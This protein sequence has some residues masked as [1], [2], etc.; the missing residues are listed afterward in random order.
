MKDDPNNANSTLPS[1][2]SSSLLYSS[3]LMTQAQLQTENNFYRQ[4]MDFLKEEVHWLKEQLG[5]LK[6]DRFGKKTEQLSTVQPELFDEAD[7]DASGELIETPEAE[8]ETLIYTRKK[9]Q[10]SKRY[11]DTSTLPRER[12]LHDLPEAEK[13]CACGKEKHKIGDDIREEIQAQRTTLKVIEHV[14]PKYA[15]RSCESVS[16]APAVEL[17]IPKSKAGTSLLV[18]IIL[19]KYAYHLP[20]YRQAKMFKIHGLNVSDNTLGYWVMSAAKV[21]EP[22]NLA[23][24]KALKMSTALQVDETP[25][26]ILKPDKKAYLWAYHSYLPGKRFIVFDFSLTRAGVNVN[27]RLDNFS[28]LLQ[29]DG[30]SG[31]NQQRARE[32]IINLGCWDHARRYFVDVVKAAGNNKTGKAGGILKLIG[33]LYKIEAEIKNATPEERYQYRQQYAKSVLEHVKSYADKIHAPP[34]SLLGKAVHYLKTQWPELI[35]YIEYGHAELANIWVENQIRPFAVGRRNWLFIGNETSGQ[36]AA[37]LYSLI[38]SCYLNDID[39]HVYLTYVLNQA[40]AMR[41]GEVDPAQL[42]PHTIDLTKLKK[43]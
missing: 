6:N 37:L 1:I 4:K 30:Y 41:K 25:V 21:L 22:L 7:L 32:D 23:L 40:H 11:L 29:S 36:R 2:V 39:P 17:P 28:G 20:L 24:F 12:K 16:M 8:E 3:L 35:R 15:C 5:L 42:L 13:T 18:E 14:R 10:R 31:Y 9:T 27:E 26:K 34:N 38:Q 43:S 19:N 33:K